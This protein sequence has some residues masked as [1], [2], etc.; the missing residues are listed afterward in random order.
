MA[1]ENE[2]ELQEQFVSSHIEDSS[3]IAN[4][5]CDSPCSSPI[6]DTYGGYP[7]AQELTGTLLFPSDS[8]DKEI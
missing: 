5:Q 4:F 2:L 1:T 6:M 3:C 8:T 7:R